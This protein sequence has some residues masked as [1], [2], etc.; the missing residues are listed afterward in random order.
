MVLPGS[1]GLPG[2]GVFPAAACVKLPQAPS[3]QLHLLPNTCSFLGL[4]VFA[5]LGVK[6]KTRS[7]LDKC[8]ALTGSQTLSNPPAAASE[9]WGYKCA[10]TTKLNF[11][12][13]AFI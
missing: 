4:F 11:Y 8:S 5:V 3:F 2:C 6:P 10:P 9:H 1:S 7:T 13:Y 12:F